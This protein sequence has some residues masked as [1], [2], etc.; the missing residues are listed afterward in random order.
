MTPSEVLVKAAD[1][2]DK[3]G[4]WDGQGDL[5]SPGGSLCAA[6][7]IRWIAPNSDS[8]PIQRAAFARLA[9]FAGIPLNDGSL[10]IADWNDAH[11]HVE[12]VT[13]MRAAAAE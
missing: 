10:A 11:T 2:I 3:H 5:P 8:W 12:V 13:A 1:L 7:A 4:W 9:D 6:L